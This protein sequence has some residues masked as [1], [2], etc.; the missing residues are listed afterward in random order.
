MWPFSFYETLSD[1]G[2]LV[3]SIDYHSHLLP[4]VDDGVGT[5][6]ETLEIL[7]NFEKQGI[8]VLWLTPHIM[9][10]IPNATNALKQRFSELL[11]VYE[12]GIQLHLA[13]EYLLDSLFDERLEDG[14]LLPIG[15]IGNHLLVETSYFT[16]PNNL[17]ETLGRIKSKGYYPVLAHPERYHYMFEKDYKKLKA[18]DVKLQLNWA[19]L[20]GGYGKSVQKKAEWLLKRNMYT[21][22]G[23]DTH[24]L[25]MRHWEMKIDRSVAKKIKSASIS[26]KNSEWNL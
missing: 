2:L 10:D 1:S 7:E 21:V 24:T 23:S 20:V 18:M 8:S 13:A 14:D 4:G 6:D 22:A 9:E 3:N 26:L 12:G 19:S 15:E 5:M 17:Y 16:P 25:A 11:Q